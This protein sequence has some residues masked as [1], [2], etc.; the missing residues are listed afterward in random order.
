MGVYLLSLSL[1]SIS[2]NAQTGTLPK[3]GTSSIVGKTDG[4]DIEAKVQSPSAQATPLQIACVFEYTANDLT[5]PPALP[6]NLNGMLHVDDALKGLITGLR[7][8]GKFKG[9][10]Y[11]TLL[12]TPA[13]G[14]MPAKQ[15]LLIGLGDRNKFDP[16]IMFTVGAIGMREALRLGVTSYSHASNLKDAGVESPT[17]VVASNVVKGAVEAY[18]TQ[19]YLKEKNMS[20]Y[21][22]L[23]KMTLLSGPAFYEVST[24]AIKEAMASF[25]N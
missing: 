11:E 23:T 2:A 21:K 5:T 17:A 15:L 1:T 14:T 18:R 9:Y 4:I 16:D 13:P 3:I 6:A 19:A 20:A 12:I 10:L 24:Q 25:N 8:S 7:A 22:P